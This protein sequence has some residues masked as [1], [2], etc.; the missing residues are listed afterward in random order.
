[1]DDNE[2][3]EY[4]DRPVRAL[5]RCGCGELVVSGEDH[6]CPPKEPVQPEPGTWVVS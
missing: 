5:R 2:R 3:P 6:T 4:L 1:M